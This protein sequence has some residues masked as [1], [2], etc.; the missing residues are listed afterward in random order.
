MKAPTFVYGRAYTR[1]KTAYGLLSEIIALTQEDARRMRMGWW[2]S[3]PGRAG[4]YLRNPPT[5][6]TTACIG[7][8]VDHLTG[9]K[10]TATG[11]RVD[12]GTL[13]GFDSSDKAI[14]ALFYGPLCNDEAQGTP[15]HARKVIALIRR[16]QRTHRRRL[17]AKKL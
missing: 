8:W 17:L 10:G 13:L 9:N 15:A 2:G 6:G 1:A 4:E 14:K 7:G 3:G 16:F 12:T 5:C 11:L